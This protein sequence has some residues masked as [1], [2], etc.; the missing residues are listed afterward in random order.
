MTQQKFTPKANTGFMFKNTYK[1]DETHPDLKGD[2]YLD[3][4]LLELLLKESSDSVVKLQLSA[5][6][7]TKDANRYLSIY[8]SK[9]IIKITK[10]QTKPL[11]EL[12]DDLPF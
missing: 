3:R 7:K 4:N 8:A 11:A 5:Y 2:V 1:K 9:P 12:L 10:P 6:C